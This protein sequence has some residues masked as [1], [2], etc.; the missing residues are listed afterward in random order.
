[1]KGADT[2]FHRDTHSKKLPKTLIPNL[3][4]I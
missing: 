3:L 1:V 4:T 2:E